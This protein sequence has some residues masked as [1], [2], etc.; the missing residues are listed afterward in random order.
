MAKG[1]MTIADLKAAFQEQRSDHPGR[2]SIQF[3]RPEKILPRC[4]RGNSSGFP[5][6]STHGH[7]IPN[8]PGC[9]GIRNSQEF[10]HASV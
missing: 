5:S 7:F 8:P 2:K 1:K 4:Y 3:S 10:R 6:G 9:R